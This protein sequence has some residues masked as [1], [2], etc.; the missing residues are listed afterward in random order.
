MKK[1]SER[2]IKLTNPTCHNCGDT[3]YRNNPYVR[4]GKVYCHICEDRAKMGLLDK[5]IPRQ[6][7]GISIGG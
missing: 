6:Y 5:K 2:K 3:I 4:G 1:E 7:M